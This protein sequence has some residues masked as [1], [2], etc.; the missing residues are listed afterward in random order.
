MKK[1]TLRFLSNFYPSLHLPVFAFL[2]ITFSLSFTVQALSQTSP[3]DGIKDN[4]P[5]VHAFTNATIVTS[6]GRVI[7]N[8]TLVIRDGVI[9]SAGRNV[10]VP[11]DARIWDMEGKTIYP[12]FIDAYTN[13]GMKSPREELDRGSRSWNPQVRSNLRA[14]E[15]YDP[16]DDGSE[17]LRA[18]GFTTALIV[19]PLGIFRGQ[20]SAISLGTKSIAERVVRPGVA[21]AVSL[22][23]S[24][25]LGYS[26]PTSPTG[27]IALIR[28]TFY[29]ADWHNRAHR[30]YE[31]N[32]SGL[33]RPEWNTSLASLSNT[34]DGSQPVL[35]ETNND[36]EILRALRFT[37]EFDITPWIKGNGHEYKLTDV[38]QDANVP[39][40]L[41]LAY[42][43]TPDIE[44]PEDALNEDLEDLRHWYLA[45][46]NPYRLEEAGIRFSLTTDGLEK[47]GDFHPNLRKA[48]KLGFSKEAALASLTTH[49]AALI[50]IDGTHGTI[51]SGKTANLVIADGDVFEDGTRILDVWV[52]GRQ[53]I[54]N[55]EKEMD[56]RGTWEVTLGIN[57]SLSGEMVIRETR[58]GR[59]GGSLTVNN[60]EIEL[61][62]VSAQ[63]V[64]RRFRADFDGSATGLNGRVR[65]TASV[66]AGGMIGWGEV[67]GQDR[68]EWSASRTADAEASE[69]REP[70]ELNRS[71][72]LADLRPSMEFGRESLPDMPRNIL[73]Q[74]ATLWTMGPDGVL[75]NGDL[76]ITEGKVAEIGTDL[77][78]P[79]NALVIDAE[80]RHVTPGLIDPHIH[81]GINGVNEVGNAIVPEVRMKDVLDIYNIWM[82]RQAAGGLTSAHAMHGSANPIGGQNIAIKMRWGA[83]SDDL[84]IEGAPRTVK[85]ALGEN[86]KRV[87]SDR[88][89][90]TRMG[91]EQIIADRFRMARDY[92]ARWNE[93]NR[94]QEG[95]PPRRNLRLDA[96]VDILNGDIL[97]QSHSYRHDEILMLMRLAEDFDFRIKAFHHGV[98]AYKVAPELA[99]HGAAA[100]VWSD[101]GAF[102]IEAFDN[103]NYN[104]RLLTEAGVLTSLHSDNSQIASRMNWEAAKM[105]RT[106]MDPVDAL[107]L[108]TLSPAKVLG[109]DDKVGSLEPGKDADF[110][111]WSGD[112]LSTFSKPEQTWIDGRKYFDLEEDLILQRRV[113][114]ERAQL[115][116]LIL[117]DN[118]D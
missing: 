60:E 63:D 96:I 69:D 45:P 1:A 40:V 36:E 50:G 10:S 99:E 107:E 54:I 93:W 113:E 33:S 6:P 26:Y 116:E 2:F 67:T 49:P 86:P 48:V 94:T 83:L 13:V 71:V 62:N 15:E 44:T 80:G 84:P 42:P 90:E 109:I 57:G 29:D 68:I 21:H 46:E 4:T 24:S 47:A 77:R 55:P 114:D 16:E 61:M 56:P 22:R 58:P 98:E 59:L 110:V 30:I 89:P 118:N 39:I 100:V 81:S 38:L 51:E 79:R 74:N 82:Y 72:E 73:V 112:P 117:E 17:E 8:G 23:R 78:A 19:P 65:L 92:E 101:W 85:F 31:N 12:G 91:T 75:E 103:T 14:E 70:S 102:K 35:F 27:A 95:I 104:A 43:E 106:G 88:Y 115:I 97:V 18:E 32:P 52:D 11:A 66:S 7:Q 5:A 20:A 105:V 25:E 34:I 9:E 108:V 3:V 53:F 64:E 87:G 41:P 28:Q 111:I 37:D 76:L